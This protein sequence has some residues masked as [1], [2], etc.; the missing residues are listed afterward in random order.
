MFSSTPCT[1]TVHSASVPS[2]AVTVYLTS[3]VKS[4]FSPEAGAIFAPG[5]TVMAGVRFVR[6]VSQGTVTVTIFVAGT[7]LISVCPVTVKAVIALAELGVAGGLGPGLET[8][9]PPPPPEGEVGPGS[10]PSS[11]EGEVGPGSDP[12]LPPEGLSQA[13]TKIPRTRTGKR[14]KLLNSRPAGGG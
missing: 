12:P 14:R 3:E 2:A 11:P 1:V 6:S 7:I 10:E 8:E 9:P 13:A 4:C 5:E